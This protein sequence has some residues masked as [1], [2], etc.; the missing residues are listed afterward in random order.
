V[1]EANIGRIPKTYIECTQDRVISPAFQR[2]MQTH[3]N[4]HSVK[5]LESSH[6]PFFSQPSNLAAALAETAGEAAAFP[7]IIQNGLDFGRVTKHSEE[8][9]RTN[10]NIR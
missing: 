10:E 1:T 2:Q 8:T 5:K 6:S 7:E 9:L 3:L 4:F